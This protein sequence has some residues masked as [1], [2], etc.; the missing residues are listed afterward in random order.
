MAKKKSRTR[1][2]SGYDY[3]SDSGRGTS[4]DSSSGHEEDAVNPAIRMTLG[5]SKGRKYEVLMMSETLPKRRPKERPV[6]KKSGKKALEP[7]NPMVTIKAEMLEDLQSKMIKEEK[8]IS[9][10]VPTINQE[11]EEENNAEPSN[12]EAE[13]VK[14]KVFLPGTEKPS[15][16]FRLLIDKNS[17]SVVMASEHHEENDD[18]GG[19]CMEEDVAMD[20]GDVKPFEEENH[21]NVQ[22]KI[23]ASLQSF[24]V[25]MCSEVIFDTDFTMCSNNE[26][27]KIGNH[28]CAFP[29][30]RETGGLFKTKGV[31][32]IKKSHK[33]GRP[34][35]V[36]FNH[37][38][39]KKFG[40]SFYFKAFH[41]HIEVRCRSKNEKSTQ[42]Y[43]MTI[44]DNNSQSSTIGA[45]GSSKFKTSSCIPTTNLTGN[46]IKY[47]LVIDKHSRSCHL[48]D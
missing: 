22:S 6:A 37:S 19:V 27:P 44:Y 21:H 17:M 10:D 23:S 47:K 48:F 36:P 28:V 12:Q 42:R 2:N 26:C 43:K 20:N 24:D 8:T 25:E 40:C 3:E 34:K 38:F 13:D 33:T 29:A 31:L 15:N 46:F 7:S 14:P 32:S 16:G 1:K 35:L 9:C 5:Q 39:L 18:L 11:I 41:G 30:I 4:S 45:A